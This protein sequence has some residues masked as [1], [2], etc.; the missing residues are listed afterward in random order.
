MTPNRTRSF[1][2]AIA[3][4][5][6][7]APLAAQAPVEITA[8][9]RALQLKALDSD[10]KYAAAL[11]DSMPEAYLRE[12][13]TPKQRHFLA[14]INHAM[15]IHLF[16]IP[17]VLGGA[18]PKGIPDTVSAY[19][20]K[21]GMKAFLTATHQYARAA[22]QAEDEK[23]RGR[24]VDLFGVKV[25]AWQTWEVAHEHTAWTLG[26]VVA[27]FRKHDMAPPGFSPL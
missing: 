15:G 23:T 26:Q 6:T 16:V 3:L 22:L 13:A 27:N 17:R 7:A 12:S 25:P 4:A 20:S 1:L 5:A 8:A 9:Y 11:V 2:I 18:P 19:A 10:F 21:A 24:I 14:Q